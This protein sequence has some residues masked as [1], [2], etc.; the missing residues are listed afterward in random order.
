MEMQTRLRQQGSFGEAEA[1]SSK[2]GKRQINPPA[3]A[4]KR[5]LDAA[6]GKFRNREVGSTDNR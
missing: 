3:A 4:R 6:L 1:I 5:P 2:T